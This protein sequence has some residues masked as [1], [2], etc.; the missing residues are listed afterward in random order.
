MLAFIALG[1]ALLPRAFS[2]VGAAPTG[3]APPPGSPVASATPAEP[4]RGS[5][6]PSPITRTH[7][8]TPDPMPA[9]MAGPA[10]IASSQNK[11]T[12][13]I[14]K[15]LWDKRVTWLQQ[16]SKQHDMVRFANPADPRPT[17]WSMPRE[18][19]AA[20]F[21]GCNI[22][23]NTTFMVVI[24]GHDIAEFPTPAEGF[25]L[26]RAV[27][28]HELLLHRPAESAL[29]PVAHFFVVVVADP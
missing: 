16:K 17:S 13:F 27:G 6:A 26:L 2:S 25:E 24:D 23:Q 14:R 18:V 9:V 12:C 19:A 3:D 8:Y 11:T 1:A 22:H 29:Q 20:V 7:L 21:A 28:P 10:V 15:S 5:T 4:V